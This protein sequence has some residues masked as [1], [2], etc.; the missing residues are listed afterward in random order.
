M[1]Y[2]WIGLGATWRSCGPLVSS[3][4]SVLPRAN[5][6]WECRHCGRSLHRALHTIHLAPSRSGSLSV[7]SSIVQVGRP[8][9]P[10]AFVRP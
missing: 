8:V 4:S 2:A 1:P 10:Q 5:D 3:A 9:P 7:A 6:Q